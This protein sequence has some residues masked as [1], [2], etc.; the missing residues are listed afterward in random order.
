MGYAWRKYIKVFLLSNGKNFQL[1]K[2][3]LSRR[4][5]ETFGREKFKLVYSQFLLTKY[6]VESRVEVV[7]ESLI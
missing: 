2:I 5:R 4:E 3:G 1:K 6:Y 7:E